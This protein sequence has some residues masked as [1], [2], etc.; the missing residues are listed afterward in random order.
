MNC[1]ILEV[2]FDFEF[3][4][5]GFWVRNQDT[6]RQELAGFVKKVFIV[7]I[8]ACQSPKKSMKIEL[9]QPQPGEATLPWF[10]SESNF[11]SMLN[12]SKSKKI[13]ESKAKPNQIQEGNFSLF[14]FI[15]L[16]KSKEIMK[17]NLN[18]TQP[19]AATWGWFWWETPA[20]RCPLISPSGLSGSQLENF[21][22]SINDWLPVA[23][24]WRPLWGEGCRQYDAS[25]SEFDSRPR[26]RK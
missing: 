2:D 1:R 21:W 4:R 24:C 10:W 3:F 9:S 7:S 16:S 17:A 20:T 13:L 26:V 14:L 19:R 23:G 8:D 18:E 11:T 25:L 15:S 5:S 22:H 6:E 12:V